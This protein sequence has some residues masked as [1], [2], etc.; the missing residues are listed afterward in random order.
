MW[1]LIGGDSEIGA[2]T[3]QFLKQRGLACA[4]TTRRRDKVD[5]DRPFL[6]LQNSLELWEP[7]AGTTAACFFAAV[8]HIANCAADP[9]GSSH[10]NVT[11]TLALADRLFRCGIPVLFLSTNQVFNGAVPNVA[12]EATYSPITEYG[13]QKAV[14][15]TAL[16][17]RVE[18]GFP[19][20]ILRLAKVVSPGMALLHNW[21][22]ML[23]RGQP[24]RAFTDMT[25]APTETEMAAAAVA[26]LMKDGARGIF[27]LTGPRDMSYFEIGRHVASKLGARRELVKESSTSAAGLPNGS[28]RLHTTLDSSR[29]RDAYGLKA[30]DVLEIVDGVIAHRRN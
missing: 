22:D 21:I 13:R 3:H 7:P 18:Q 16:R 12:P 14:A 8:A 6:D 1:L 10:V 9:Q 20:S 27:Q 24:I 25:M 15:E 5:A 26:A 4:A 28:A 17:A 29:L 23:A 19:A 30:P 11:Q 2:A